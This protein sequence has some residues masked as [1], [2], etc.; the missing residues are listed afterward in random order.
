MS[1][2]CKRVVVGVG[3][4]GDP[5][6]TQAAPQSGAEEIMASAPRSPVERAVAKL[7]TPV[8]GVVP[9]ATGGRDPQGGPHHPGR[10]PLEHWRL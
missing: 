5:A 10:D 1:M 7:W 2:E 4:S 3:T 6:T 8:T 9:I